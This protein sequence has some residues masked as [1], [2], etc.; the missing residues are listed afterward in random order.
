M[1]QMICTKC[2]HVGKPKKKVKGSIFIEIILWLMLIVP[3]LIYSIWK[4]TLQK[5]LTLLAKYGT[6]NMP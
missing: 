5:T 6:I 4:E 2:G 3:G 1:K